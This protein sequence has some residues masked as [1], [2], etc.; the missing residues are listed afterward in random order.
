MGNRNKKELQGLVLQSIG[1]VSLEAYNMALDDAEAEVAKMQHEEHR[2]SQFVH[3]CN[4]VRD[5]ILK[6]KIKE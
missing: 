6:L 4:I 2:N 3:F 5:V 1:K